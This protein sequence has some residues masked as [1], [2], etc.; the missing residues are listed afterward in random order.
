MPNVALRCDFYQ[1]KS[2]IACFTFFASKSAKDN[3]MR[4]TENNIK[5]PIAAD[6]SH[7]RTAPPESIQEGAFLL[8][9]PYDSTRKNGSKG[10]NSALRRIFDSHLLHFQHGVYIVQQSDNFRYAIT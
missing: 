8:L 5:T 6:A 2:T 1:Y 10:N 4:R 7:S 9:L 3:I